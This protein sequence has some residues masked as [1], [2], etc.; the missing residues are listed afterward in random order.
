MIIC[1]KKMMRSELRDYKKRRKGKKEKIFRS[2]KVI[3][4]INSI[5]KDRVKK[6]IQGED[7]IEINRIAEMIEIG[8]TETIIR[9]K[10]TIKDLEN[11]ETSKILIDREIKINLN[12][13]QNIK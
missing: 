4:M 11:R 10:I 13:N 5:I 1:S 7:K 3:R 8:I 9:I 12:I 6:I 2:I